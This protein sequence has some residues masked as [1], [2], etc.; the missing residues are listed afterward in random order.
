VDDLANFSVSDASS[1]EAFPIPQIENN[2]DSTPSTCT[3]RRSVQDQGELCRRRGAPARTT[4]P[5]VGSSRIDCR[6]PPI[7][8]Q[9]L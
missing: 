1:Q 7:A 6:S 8:D 3:R 5:F 2:E 4:S 9:S